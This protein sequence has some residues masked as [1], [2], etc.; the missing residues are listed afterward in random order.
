MYLNLQSIFVKSLINTPITLGERTAG[1]WQHVS[2]VIRAISSQLYKNPVCEQ[3][4]FTF[5]DEQP[6]S[7]ELS[8]VVKVTCSEA[9][10]TME[11]TLF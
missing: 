11:A 6:G 3:L 5:T 10:V 7:K 4:A 2:C 1:G 9:P 8:D